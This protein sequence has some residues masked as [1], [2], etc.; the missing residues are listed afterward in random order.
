M[1]GRSLSSI[2]LALFLIGFGINTVTNIQVAAIVVGVLALI[3]G[4]LILL[5]Q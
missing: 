2:T 3:A 1:N 5:K 4:V